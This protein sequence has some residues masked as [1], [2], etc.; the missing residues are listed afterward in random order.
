MGSWRVLCTPYSSSDDPLKQEEN[1]FRA[2]KE[3]SPFG[4][5]FARAKRRRK[6]GMIL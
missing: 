3:F 5:R 2:R 4:P 1:S 6:K